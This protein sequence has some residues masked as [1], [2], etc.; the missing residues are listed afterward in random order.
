LPVD[1]LIDCHLSGVN[2]ENLCAGLLVWQRELDLPVQTTRSKQGG[3]QDINSVGGSKN[4]DTVIGR[5]TIQLVEKLQHSSLYFSVT[6]L[7]RV[8]SLRAD[9]V[10]FINED[11]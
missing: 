3:I 4:L 5:E 11:D 9:C 1:T 7:L 6:R 8:E 2:A 10:Q